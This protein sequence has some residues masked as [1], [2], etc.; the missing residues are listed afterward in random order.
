MSS[1]GEFPGFAQMNRRTVRAPINPLD[2]S[3]I[4]S[5]LPKRIIETKITLTPSIYE[6]QPGTFD[7]PALLVVTTGSWWKEIDPEQ[8]L[9]EI[10][11]SS[12]VIADSIVKDYCVGLIACNMNDAMPGISYLPGKYDVQKL[13]KEQ[14]ALLN[15]L[16]AKQRNW[17]KELI[18]QADIMWSRTNGNPLAIS[19]DARLACKEL[20]ITNKPWL[21]DLQAMELVRCVACG[22]MRNPSFPICPTCKA[23]ADPELAKTLNI[24]FAQ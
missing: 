4:I 23:V 19:D 14:G 16:Y 11:Q 3:T 18:R 1:V 7:N 24:S 8:P 22:S 15:S 21:G 2:V 17:Y 9:L 6:I 12:I 20:N 13:K 10:T 5:I